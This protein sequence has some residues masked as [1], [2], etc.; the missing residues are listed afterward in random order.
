MD[1]A[2]P[3]ALVRVHCPLLGFFGA[4]GEWI[5]LER[6]TKCW[7]TATRGSRSSVRTVRLPGTTH[8]PTL[9]GQQELTAISPVYE[10]TWSAWLIEQFVT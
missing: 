7:R 2:P 3:A 4:Q 5:P 10:R 9:R 6:S 8:D 1:L